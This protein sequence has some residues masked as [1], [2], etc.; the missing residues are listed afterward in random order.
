M[1][2]NALLLLAA[3]EA[4][5]MFIGGAIVALVVWLVVRKL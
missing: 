2:F 1:I 4:P 3:R 5:A